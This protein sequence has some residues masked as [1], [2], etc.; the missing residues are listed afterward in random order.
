MPYPGL[1][2]PELLPLQQTTA[3]QYL[4]RRH[5]NTQR[6]VWLCLC[7]VS[8]CAQGF[9]WALWVSLVGMEFDYKCNFDPPTFLLEF[10]LCRWTWGI[11]MRQS[12]VNGCSAV[13]C[14]FE[15][16][17]GEGE[18]AFFYS[19]ILCINRWSILKSDWLYSFQPKMEKLYIVS[20]NKTRSWL[21][22]RSWTPYCQ[23]QTG[24]EESRENH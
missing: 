3:D 20:K 2:H 8:W 23:I 6:Q 14:N 12:P 15:V 16:L 13:S 17:L 22:F 24:I 7:G 21:R 1:L 10:L 11:F 5:S 9:V 19:T 18:W 4:C